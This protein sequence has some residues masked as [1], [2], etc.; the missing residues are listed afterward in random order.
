VQHRCSVYGQQLLRVAG[1]AAGVV[2]A[3]AWSV[4]QQRVVALSIQGVRTVQQAHAIVCTE[5]TKSHWC[6]D[7]P[8]QELV[9]GVSTE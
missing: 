1:A 8:W 5:R 7:L 2:V 3:A 6:I 9:C 4:G